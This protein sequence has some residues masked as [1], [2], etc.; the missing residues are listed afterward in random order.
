MQTHADTL[1]ATSLQQQQQQQRES[2]QMN[3]G[4]SC[5][6]AAQ[7]MGQPPRRLN[8][9]Q[10]T[11]TQLRNRRNFQLPNAVSGLLLLQQVQ[12]FTGL[13]LAADNY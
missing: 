4:M 1:K 5:E 7:L 13:A 12:P 6:A 9:E 11:R 2:Q 8:L 10:L 3:S